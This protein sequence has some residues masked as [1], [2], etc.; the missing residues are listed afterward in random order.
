[1]SNYLDHLIARSLNQAETVQPRLPSLFEPL[2]WAVGQ[3]QLSDISLEQPDVTVASEETELAERSPFQMPKLQ[4]AQLRSP[5]PTDRLT[6]TVDRLSPTP[7]EKT[8]LVPPA[9]PFLPSPPPTVL[10]SPPLASEEIQS[11]SSPLLS[12]S[13]TSTELEATPSGNSPKTAALPAI[14]PAV[15]QQQIIVERVE[16]PLPIWQ[17]QEILPI[18]PMPPVE[19]PPHEPQPPLN[20]AIA[21]TL[22]E[23]TIAATQ[24]PIPRSPTAAVV[25]PQITPSRQPVIATTEPVKPPQ[26]TPTIQVTIGRIE[27]RA[28]PAAPVQPK[29][30]PASPA[31]SLDE[32]L[33]QRGGAK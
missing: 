11:H 24:P 22:A 6:S 5:P 8:S 32:Y 18:Q 2:P 14:Q 33:R 10:P 25:Q 19:L 9:S 3:N 4:P 30:R 29:P 23:T 20:Q 17:Q 13:T 26:P 31:M 15:V 1:M 12:P 27:V 16:Q 7:A 21:P 28:T